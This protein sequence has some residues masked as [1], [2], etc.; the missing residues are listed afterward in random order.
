MTAVALEA[1]NTGRFLVRP[2]LFDW[3]VD[4][5]AADTEVAGDRDLATRIVDQALAF[6]AAS[7]TSPR[8]L[9]PSRLVDVGWHTFLLH[10]REYAAWCDQVAGRFLHHIP[11]DPA[12]APIDAV[13]ARARTLTAIT[14]A[15]YAVD[16]EL[17]REVASTSCAD[18]GDCSASG[19]D[20]NENQDTRI[21]N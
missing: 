15:G 3:L 9:A 5:V 14:E 21:P 11:A 16:T 7:A 20:G 6:L 12:D 19:E 8:T 13:A 2:A 18:K 17:W 4:R 1:A 10:T